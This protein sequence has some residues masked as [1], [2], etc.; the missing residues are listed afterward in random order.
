MN[1][2]ENLT[3]I[4]FAISQILYSTNA[5]I[6]WSDNHFVSF[7]HFFPPVNFI[8]PNLVFDLEV[9]IRLNI[10]TGMLTR[11]F[12]WACLYFSAIETIK[13]LVGYSF[14]DVFRD[15]YISMCH[16]LIVLELRALEISSGWLQCEDKILKLLETI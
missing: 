7:L 16:A 14:S 5:E 8:L 13:G 11:S 9:N 12:G 15:K 2:E 6:V 3:L 10:L 4:L 1:T